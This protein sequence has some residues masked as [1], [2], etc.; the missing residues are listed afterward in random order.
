MTAFGSIQVS[1]KGRAFS[2]SQRNAARDIVR[3]VGVLEILID[4]LDRRLQAVQ[5]A[6]K[7]FERITVDDDVVGA[8]AVCGRHLAGDVGLLTTAGPAEHSWTARSGRDLESATAPPAPLC[9]S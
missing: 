1:A 6:L 3:A 7:L 8:E 4:V 2:S 9:R 5:R